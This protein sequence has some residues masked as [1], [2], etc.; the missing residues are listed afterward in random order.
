MEKSTYCEKCDAK[1]C[2][3]TCYLTF[4]RRNNLILNIRGYEFKAMVFP[5]KMD[6]NYDDTDTVL[7]EI[8]LTLKV[9]DYDKGQ[10]E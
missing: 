1:V 9:I 5:Q 6:C 7:K 4:E 2:K 8:I 3:N 10:I